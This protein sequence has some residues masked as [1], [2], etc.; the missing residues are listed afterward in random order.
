MVKIT[1]RE[2]ANVLWFKKIKGEDKTRYDNF[3]LS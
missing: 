3:Y 2:H 1:K